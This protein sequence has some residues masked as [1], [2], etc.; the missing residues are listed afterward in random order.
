MKE[1][2]SFIC[3]QCGKKFHNL[4]AVTGHKRIHSL[5]YKKKLTENGKLDRGVKEE[6]CSTF[7]D[8]E[9]DEAANAALTLMMLR[10][11]SRE[12]GSGQT[13]MDLGKNKSRDRSKRKTFKCA[14]CFKEFASGNAL[15]GHMRAHYGK[16]LVCFKEFESG[17]DLEDHKRAA[18]CVKIGSSKDYKCSICFRKFR[19]GTALGGHKRVHSNVITKQQGSNVLDLHQ[20]IQIG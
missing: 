11:E 16:C 14:V 15:G 2:K 6:L 20:E 7:D 4:K 9:Q 3:N 8:M 10:G 17:E 12:L 19:S 13:S 1:V 5:K 18:C